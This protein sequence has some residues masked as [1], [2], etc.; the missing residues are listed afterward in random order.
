MPTQINNSAS[1]TYGYGRTGSDSA[2]SNVATATLLEQFSI[3]GSKNVQNPSF[4]P[5]EN[6][7]YYIQ[8][9]NTGT[10]SLFNVTVEDDLGGA[11]TPLSYVLG[12]AYLNLNGTITE[13]NPTQESPLTFI[14]PGSLA[15]GDI[16]TIDFEG[17]TDGVAFEGGKGENYSLE[18][19]SNSFVPGFEE[20]LVGVKSEDNVEVKVT[21]PEKYG[22]EDLAGKDAE[23][24]VLVHEVKKTV[25]PEL[26]DE[27]VVSLEL[28]NIKTVD[29]WKEYLKSN[30]EA[31]TTE[32]NK[33]KYEDEVFTKVL[34]NNP[35]VI[36]QE[37]IDAQ[38]EQ[39][40]NQMNEMA[41]SYGIPVEYFLQYQGIKDV[42]QYKELVTPGIKG[43][44][45]FEVVI[46]AIA[47]A[48]KVKLTK[49]DYEKYYKVLAKGKDLKEVKAQ[50]PKDKVVSY[51]TLLKTQD[52]ILANVK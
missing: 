41:K 23:F 18:L 7:S 14:L 49:E 2:T 13:I 12:S 20:Q 38:V 5:G 16:A 11:D 19:G 6:L 47:K 4:R 50:Y 3:T 42:E 44:I 31:E 51:F 40:V 33:N 34:E 46:E 48:E 37:M 52:L 22:K 30:L 32:A 35:I 26:T 17:F 24:K 36:P 15:G 10:D 45:H 9:R 29:A 39:K 8:V 21:F 43:Q 1:I 28:E 27:F 25:L